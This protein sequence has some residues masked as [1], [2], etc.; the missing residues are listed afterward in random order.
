[1]EPAAAW[2]GPVVAKPRS[3]REI[4]HIRCPHGTD[5]VAVARLKKEIDFLEAQRNG[6]PPLFV[7]YFTENS[8]YE[9]LGDKLRISLETRNL[10]HRI[11]PMQST[12]SWVGDTNLKAQVME[13]IWHQS[14]S[15]VCWIDAD[16]EIMRIPNVVFDN[17]F[18]LAVVRR[19]G[20]NDLSG[21]V[22]V[23]KTASAQRFISLWSKL[24]RHHSKVWD[25]V[26]FSIAWYQ[27]AKREPFASLWINDGFFRFPRPP[28]RDLRDRLLY[29]PFKTKVRPFVNQKQASRDYERSRVPDTHGHDREFGS[30]HVSV[31]FRRA[32]IHHDFA[33]DAQMHTVFTVGSMHDNNTMI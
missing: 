6:T 29:Y 18:D 15:P 4:A 24:S 32:L 9:S 1:M 7:S 2:W 27:V 25:Q 3:G 8:L 22:Y 30:D 31:A 23:G 16:A 14:A 13:K 5:T 26:L 10:P 11:V 12:G 19:D 28:I 21:F 17:P 20:W 33:F